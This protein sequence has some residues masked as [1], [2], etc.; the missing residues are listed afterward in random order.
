ME[1]IFEQILSEHK[2][3]LNDFEVNIYYFCMILKWIEIFGKQKLVLNDFKTE[4]IRLENGNYIWT[5]Y[6]WTEKTVNTK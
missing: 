1:T 4:Q 6:K 3:C 2:L 5:L